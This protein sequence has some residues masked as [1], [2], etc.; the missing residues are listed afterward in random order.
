LIRTVEYGAC[1]IMKNSTNLQPDQI[2]FRPPNI[3]I[4]IPSQNFFL[5]HN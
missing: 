3:A 4:D 1:G 2:S 5:V